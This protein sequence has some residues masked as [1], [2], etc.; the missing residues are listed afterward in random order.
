ML[1]LFILLFEFIRWC[2]ASVF[3]ST[4]FWNSLQIV[5]LM[6][7]YCKSEFLDKSHRSCLDDFYF[8]K[9]ITRFHYFF[10]KHL[11]MKIQ[12]FQ[13]EQINNKFYCC[14]MLMILINS[15][16]ETRLF[17][18]KPWRIFNSTVGVILRIYRFLKNCLQKTN[19]FVKLNKKT[20]HT[21]CKPSFKSHSQY[22]VTFWC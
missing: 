1:Y 20:R 17:A 15:L 10:R 9:N 19:S 11:E 21:T 5:L 6:M 12:E 3:I 14:D 4:D 8:L 22:F 2:D 16:I 7:Q 18:I 13:T